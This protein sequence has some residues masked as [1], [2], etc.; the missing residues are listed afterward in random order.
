MRVVDE[1]HIG[2]HGKFAIEV[3]AIELDFLWYPQYQIISGL[4]D[5][6]PRQRPAAQGSHRKSQA[7]LL[8]MQFALDEIGLWEALDRSRTAGAKVDLLIISAK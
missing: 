8:A 5:Q 7:V 3:S 4:R 6:T 2:R 1:V